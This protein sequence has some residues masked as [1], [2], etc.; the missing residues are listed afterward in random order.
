MSGMAVPGRGDMPPRGD[1]CAR[2]GVTTPRCDVLLRGGK[3][4]SRVEGPCGMPSM[5]A[6]RTGTPR[7]DAGGDQPIRGEAV[8]I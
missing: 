5:V 8:L 7:D 3:V 4:I 2:R 6:G 1:L